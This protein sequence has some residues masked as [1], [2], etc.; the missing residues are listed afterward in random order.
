MRMTILT[1]KKV[2]MRLEMKMSRQTRL[3]CHDLRGVSPA[4]NYVFVYLLNQS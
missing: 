4:L 2:K 3:A 1:E